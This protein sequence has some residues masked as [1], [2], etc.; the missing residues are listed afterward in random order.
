MEEVC[1]EDKEGLKDEVQGCK[2]DNREDE[3]AEKQAEERIEDKERL[4][5][6]D[7]GYKVDSRE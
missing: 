7:Q 6:E 5:D 2:V 3:R 4:K 1:N